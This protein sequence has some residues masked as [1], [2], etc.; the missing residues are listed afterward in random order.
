MRC[1]VEAND[2]DHPLS[3][4]KSKWTREEKE[5]Q[6]LLRL[7]M[8]ARDFRHA[9]SDAT[10]LIEECDWIKRHSNAERPKFH[11]YETTMVVA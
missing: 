1:L 4:S 3:V 8:S 9:L 6:Q 7:V 5:H 2:F 11:C 10:F